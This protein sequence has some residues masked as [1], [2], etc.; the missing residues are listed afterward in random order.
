MMYLSISGISAHLE[1]YS[2][3]TLS[4]PEEP[5]KIDE[6]HGPYERLKELSLNNFGFLQ[7][8]TTGKDGNLSWEFVSKLYSSQSH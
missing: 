8:T 1:C 3:N 7:Q 5:F 4:R 2:G 6:P